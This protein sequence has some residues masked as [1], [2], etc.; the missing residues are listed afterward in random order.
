[1]Y[2][3]VLFVDDDPRIL[4]SFKRSLAQHFNVF[5][6]DSPELGLR[7]I[8]QGGPFS[9]IVS[10]MRMPGMNGIEFFSQV[11]QRGQD[12]TR[13]LLTG[14]ADQHTA[15]EAVNRGKVFRFLTKPCEVE[16]LVPILR[17]G[18]D[19]YRRVVSERGVVNATL[20]GVVNL[21]SQI[22]SL[23]NPEAQRKANRVKRSCRHLADGLP[24]HERWLVESAALLSQLGALPQAQGGSDRAGG[25]PALVVPG[26]APAAGT[27]DLAVRLLMHVPAFEDVTAILSLLTTPWQEWSTA[28]EDGRLAMIRRCGLMLR[29]ALDM[30]ELLLSGMDPDAALA[31]LRRDRDRYEPALLDRL[32]CCD[33]GSGTGARLKVRL[34]ELQPGMVLDQDVLDVNDLPVAHRYQPVTAVLKAELEECNRNRGIREPVAVLRA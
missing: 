17:E 26:P 11:Q 32:S 10:D 15:I 1:M 34:R 31:V 3:S 16:T 20:S 12:S 30:D 19:Q 23:T 6:A 24:L 28:L 13:I 21:L 27:F 9:V 18:V 7:L 2:A 8:D 29:A 25:C 14:Y 5:T 4:T 22:L 33:F